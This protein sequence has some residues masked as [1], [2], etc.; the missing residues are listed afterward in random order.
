MGGT[1]FGGY[2]SQSASLSKNHESLSKRYPLD[3]Q[4]RFG[5][6]DR[7]SQVVISDDPEATALEFFKKLGEG[8]SDQTMS[9][10]KIQVKSFGA[11]SLVVL[12]LESSD[13]S[14]AIT[15]QFG[16]RNK[17]SYKIHFKPFGYK[18]KGPN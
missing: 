7:G 12:R 10:G 15:L 2:A 5:S 4:G 14:P 9:A 1:S 11:K 3:S 16:P 18:A 8:G 6:K 17:Q 13:G